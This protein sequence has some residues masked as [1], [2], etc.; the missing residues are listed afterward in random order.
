MNL[1]LGL[2]LVLGLAGCARVVAPPPSAPVPAPT[3]LP[4]PH[5][6]KTFGSLNAFP[7]AG[8]AVQ[9][10]KI[11][12]LIDPPSAP[13]DT[14]YLLLSGTDERR[15]SPALQAGLRKNI[16]ILSSPTDA[17][18][19]AKSGFTQVKALGPGQ[20]I[21]LKKEDGFL[22]ASAAAGQSYFLE[23]DN[24]KNIFIA[25][26]VAD[27]DSL[28]DFLYSLRDDG[29][30]IEIGF[31]RLT[32]TTDAA[33]LAQTIGLLQPKN[34]VLLRAPG[35]KNVDLNALREQLKTEFFEGPIAVA[36]TEAMDF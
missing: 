11:S 6:E 12:L 34:V 28:R 30:A 24:G 33:A 23:F 2:V 20:R 3:P 31:F 1:W 18:R 15:W 32:P 25:G 35:A 29:R 8:L 13:A 27:A 5:F 22:F 4:T 16:K 14:D 17:A 36:G 26:D 10:K 19:I 21:L 7:N 9:Y